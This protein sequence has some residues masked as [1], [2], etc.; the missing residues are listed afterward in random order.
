MFA[1]PREVWVEFLE[2]EKAAFARH[3]PDKHCE[4]SLADPSQFAEQVRAAD[5]IYIV[6]GYTHTLVE[7]LKHLR[8][9]TNELDGKTLAGSSAGADAIATYHY[10]LDLQSLGSGLGLLPIKM[11]PHWRS[12]YG[13]G[14]IDWDKAYAELKAYGED[15]PIHTLA[16]GQFEVF[17]Q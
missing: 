17:E 14:K 10:N 4:L 12:N 5:T 2:K 13:D 11:I 7:I 1:R 6:G 16:E 9:W 8:G 15:R 3:V